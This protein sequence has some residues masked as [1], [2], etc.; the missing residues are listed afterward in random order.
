MERIGKI[1]V[2]VM[3]F[4]AVAVKGYA[5]PTLSLSSATGEIGGTTTLDISISGD[6]GTYAGMNARIILPEGVSVTEVT[7][8]DGL[9]GNFT[10]EYAVS[11]NNEVS[12]IA[13]SSSKTFSGNSGELL[14]L[15][16]KIAQTA[17]TGTHE[18]KFASSDTNNLI[19]SKHAV[20]NT[21]GSTSVA[22]AT[23]DGTITIMASSGTPTPT[24][25]TTP[26]PPPGQTGFIAGIVTDG[27][28]KASISGA[29]VKTDKGGY[30]ATTDSAGSYQISLVTAGNY[31]LEA[32]ATGYVT[33]TQSITVSANKIT[34]ANFTLELAVTSGKISGTV[35][36]ESDVPVKKAK[37]KIKRE[38]TKDK[39]KTDE[40][41]YFEFTKLKK[42]TYK[43]EAKK[44]GYK[45]SKMSVT[46]ED[47]EQEE[48]KL[49]LE[50]K[51]KSK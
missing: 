13:Y 39:T 38:S 24:I 37:V 2:F 6:T 41:G 5:K 21:D 11:S 32:S 25:T 27:K 36:D 42:G 10:T 40:N 1:I 19:N 14:S 29:Q 44:D 33:S 26:T 9:P 48:I 15:K 45:K 12:V 7:A 28:T 22:H 31:N 4:V 51:S 43:I 23:R 20:S 30:S 8:G 46:L 35:V 16:L 49:V 50:K 47:D 18:V 17:A 34:T 3:L